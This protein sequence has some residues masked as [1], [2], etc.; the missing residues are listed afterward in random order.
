MTCATAIQQLSLL[1][2]GLITSQ[3]HVHEGIRHADLLK[4]QVV[5]VG[6]VV[7]KLHNILVGLCNLGISKMS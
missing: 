4:R 1:S 5:I 2:H 7:Q 6:L 3:W